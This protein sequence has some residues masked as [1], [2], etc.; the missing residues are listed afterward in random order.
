M[1]DHGIDVV[2]RACLSIFI[3]LKKCIQS[4]DMDNL[5]RHYTAK[6][7]KESSAKRIW[8]EWNQGREWCS[9]VFVM[10]FK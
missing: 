2:T 7:E 9:G 5:K 8:S 10:H 4:R 6:E 1:C 3:L